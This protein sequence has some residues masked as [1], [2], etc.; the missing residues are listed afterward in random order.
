MFFLVKL[1]GGFWTGLKF[2]LETTGVHSPDG[3]S[4]I[5]VE[6]FSIDVDALCHAPG[7]Q[8]KGFV[9]WLLQIV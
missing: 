9:Y 1:A 2:S 7:I 6:H 8:L 3:G 5:L 4:T